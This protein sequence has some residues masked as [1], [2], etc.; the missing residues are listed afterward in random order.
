MRIM[1]SLLILILGVAIGLKL[2]RFGQSDGNPGP[3]VATAAKGERKILY[4]WDPM[5]PDYRSDQ[6]GLSPMGMEMVPV[7]A[8]EGSADPGVVTIAPEVVNNLGVRIALASRGTLARRIDTVGQVEYDESGLHHVHVRA[9]GWIQRLMVKAEG[10]RVGPGQLLFGV[11]APALVNAQEEYLQ[12]LSMGNERLI[13]ASR[14]RLAALGISAG[15]IARLG[16]RRQA[17]PLVQVYAHPH[18]GGVVSSLG[19]REGMYVKPETEIMTVVDLG[20]VWLIAEVFERQAGWVEL[21]QAAEARIPSMHGRVWRGR[22]DYLYPELEPM[23]RTLRVRL[24]FDNPDEHLKPKMFAQVSLLS[25][26]RAEVVTI[27]REALIRDGDSERVVLA[28]GRGRFRPRT[29]VPGIESGD[30]IEIREGLEAGDAVVVSAQFLIDSEAS[31][32]GSFRR[33]EAPSGSD[34]HDGSRSPGNVE[35]RP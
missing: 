11:Y 34:S 15:Q 32:R 21:G 13:R 29:V 31:L 2:D 27:P 24:R 16:E 8:G 3:A 35:T 17:D 30:R 23:T 22:V 1:I 20:S 19:V 12:A 5:I 33:M 4:W 9:E 6:P 28:L 10:E 7:Y 14:Q 18:R 25:A 26:P